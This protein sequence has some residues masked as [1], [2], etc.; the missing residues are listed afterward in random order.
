MRVVKVI[1]V[2]NLTKVGLNMCVKDFLDLFLNLMIE[3]VEKPILAF[4]PIIGNYPVLRE[5]FLE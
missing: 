1:C 4:M 2:F 3:Y 5:K